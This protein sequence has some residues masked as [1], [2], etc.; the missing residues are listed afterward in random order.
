MELQSDEDSLD[1]VE[2]AALL[3]NKPEELAGNCPE[4][5]PLLS[6]A[7]L[8]DGTTILDEFDIRIPQP[9]YVSKEPI[10]TKSL[11]AILRMGTSDRN[12]GK[13]NLVDE[14]YESEKRFKPVDSDDSD[15]DLF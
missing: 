1:Y 6:E 5:D 8:I 9:Q 12:E 2:N 11:C 4:S 3:L 10:H 15:S 14:T 13:R 7:Q